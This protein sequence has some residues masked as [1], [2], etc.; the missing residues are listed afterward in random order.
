MAPILL[1]LLAWLIPWTPARANSPTAVVVSVGDGDT[2]RL[3]QGSR[4]LTVRLACIDAPE[5][6]QTPHGQAA[7]AAL[8]ALAP[9]G[10]LLHL[11]RLS[12]DRY[13]RTVAELSRSGR[14]LNQRLV[15]SGAAFV[16]WPYIRGCDR[17]TYAR[18]ETEARLQRLGVWSVEGG[19]SR[20][21]DARRR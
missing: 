3:R 15:A 1:S 20:P 14:N 6:W 21:W 11:R 5:R 12:S 13:G 19:I 2:L 10:A 17:Q 4:L 18:L 7:R 9:P 8:L 16:Y